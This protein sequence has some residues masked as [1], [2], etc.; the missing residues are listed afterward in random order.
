MC[1]STEMSTISEYIHKFKDSPRSRRYNRC[2]NRRIIAVYDGIISQYGLDKIITMAQS[3]EI[4]Y[5]EFHTYV[6][7]EFP[8]IY[9]GPRTAMNIEYNNILNEPTIK[10][11][12]LC[13][14]SPLMKYMNQWNSQ[15][16]TYTVK[17]W[18]M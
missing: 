12:Y 1:N 18:L 13:S 5:D 11:V 6:A 9:C 17:L 14:W 15:D 10:V 7:I 16:P 4:S 3:V 2:K 8:L